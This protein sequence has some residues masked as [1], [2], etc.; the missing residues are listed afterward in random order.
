VKPAVLL[1]A[2]HEARASARL[3]L[4]L[5][6]GIALVGY[7]VTSEY[8]D[9]RERMVSQGRHVPA[10]LRKL[11]EARAGG[12]NFET[13][14]PIAYVHPVALALMASWPI[15]RAS[16]AVAGD[17]ERGALG[18]HLSYPIGRGAFL[19]GKAS[20][21]LLGVA[22]MQ[23]VLFGAFRVSLW[24]FGLANAGPWPYA[25][26]GIVGALL[27]GAV[28][29]LTLW[30]SAASGRAAVPGMVGAGLVLGSV[31]LENV[32]GVYPLFERFR[33]LSLYHYYPYSKLIGGAAMSGSDVGVL[34]A[35]LVLGLLGATWSFCRRD[36]PI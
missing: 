7:V 5:S 34:S 23:F 13:L 25:H 4:L 28:G 17:L 18:W 22:L 19:W 3:L 9:F 21:M 11:L 27:Y 32:G 36:L 29:T 16:R 15:A 31:L 35:A 14:A 1:V 20:V 26:A 33:W 8:P 24:H 2:A 10:F 12:L 30:V 6:L